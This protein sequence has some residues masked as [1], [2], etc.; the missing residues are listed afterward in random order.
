MQTVAD[1][2]TKDVVTVKPET[3]IR[4]LAEIFETRRFGTLPVIDD[5]GNL[6]GIVTESDLV[7]QG[8]NLHI[9]T[10]IS[11]FDWV[12]PLE[13]ERTLERELQRMTAQTVGEIYTKDIKT[14][15]PSEGIS[16]AADVMS[17]NKLH[18]LPVTVAGKLVGIVS[19]IDIIRNMIPT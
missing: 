2:M 11:V 7:E 13:G 18:A 12:I 4:Q 8:K 10:V 15:A 6:V 14:V 5:D 9:P 17:N 19:R 16:S 3:T 1:I